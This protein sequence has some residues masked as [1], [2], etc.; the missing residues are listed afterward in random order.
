MKIL[1]TGATGFVGQH[2]VRR[3]ISKKHQVIAVARDE[4]KAQKFDWYDQVKFIS[5]DIHQAK[6]NL[7]LKN[8]ENPKTVMHL[9]W[10]GL[11]DYK[12]IH[13]VTEN[14]PGDLQFLHKIVEQG[15][16]Q[17]LVTGTC[18][19]YGQ[20]NGSLSED[21][22]TMPNNPYAL[23]KDTLRRSLEFIKQDLPFRLQWVRLFYMYGTGQNP[24]SLL[25]QLDRAIKEGKDIFEMSGGE[26]LRD[27][28]PIE[29][30][31]RKLVDIVENQEWQGIVNCCN[32]K[33]ISVRS[34]VESYLERKGAKMKLDIGYYP[35][36][37]YEPMAFWGNNSKLK[38]ILCH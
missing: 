24:N 32:S 37:D 23:A 7:N 26:Q 30:V 22:P 36:P 28:L 19:E 9:A 25:A 33:P 27:Y 38:K 12:S 35:Y 17:V 8:W 6:Q 15:I 14:L 31:A 21:K 34:L 18:F 4:E 1:V 3:L 11:P 5:Y 16:E 29:E 10:T 2:V 20:Q 13:H